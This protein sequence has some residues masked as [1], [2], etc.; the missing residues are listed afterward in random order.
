LTGLTVTLWDSSN[1]PSDEQGVIYRWSGHGEVNQVRS[2]LRYA[3]THGERL[4]R[5]YLAWIHDL[6]ESRIAG[7]RL[8]DHLVLEDGLSYWWLTLLVEKSPWKSPSINAAIRL[9]ALEEIVRD[10]RPGTLRVV[11]ANQPV[12]AAIRALCRN[13][14][15]GYEWRRIAPQ[16][17]R[18]WRVADLYRRLP[19]PV[20]ALLFLGRHVWARWPL[21]SS[22]RSGWLSGERTWFFCS[23]FIHLDEK[24]C[25]KGE[26]HSRQWEALPKLVHDMGYG[27]NW[28]QHFLPSSAVPHTAVAQEW[29][30]RFNLQGAKASFH[31]FLD[32]YLSWP[33]VLRV[34]TRWLRLNFINLR[35]RR[36]RAAFRPA[37]SSL[38]LWPLARADWQDS[39]A[40]PAAIGNLL[41][42]ELFDAV[43]RA[44]PRQA[45]GLYLCEGQGWERAFIHAWRKHGHGRLIAVEH[46]TV[47]FWD[48]RYFADPR[49]VR[50]SGP[51]SMPQPD[52]TAVNGRAALQAY[53][54]ADYPPDGVTECEALRYQ[55]LHDLPSRSGGPRGRI[56]VLI[57]GDVARASTNKLL[58][59]LEEAL[60]LLEEARVPQAA[61]P[62]FTIKPHPNCMVAVE[63]HPS[64]HLQ[65]RTNRI[66]EILCD[67]D[68]AYCS[69]STSAAVDAYLAGLRVIVMLDEA[70]LNISP[71]RGRRGVHFVS[72]PKELATALLASD[73]APVSRS[74]EDFFCLD[75]GLPRWQR[76]LGCGGLT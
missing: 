69:N 28:L 11:S 49:S 26:F 37:D 56:E 16:A 63:N 35:L 8:I 52:V 71:L 4:R 10:L 27:A 48:L 66:G 54:E 60:K 1:D 50:R 30:R 18:P 38:W 3:E 36:V 70:E 39:L 47:R 6:G 15:V 23:Y 44:I 64:L 76:L 17:S 41:W 43:L 14:G 45:T 13:L 9:L 24:S 12:A 74:R 19:Q 2:L 21:R 7:R 22:D 32:A 42:I 65:L 34:L 72:T 53:L 40:G 59:L 33:I 55:Y 20:R 61:G 46:S 25:A 57:L 68:V 62:N 29:V 67:F 31:C 51:G 5:K 75:P 73:E 58:Q